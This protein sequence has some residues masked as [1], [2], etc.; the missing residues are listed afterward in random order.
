MLFKKNKD[1]IV[2]W[3]FNDF[4]FDKLSSVNISWN[5]KRYCKNYIQICRV[6]YR[7]LQHFS[8]QIIQWENF[9]HSSFI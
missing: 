6:G 8:Q 3:K 5:L 2:F 7:Y 4:Q 1:A 9:I